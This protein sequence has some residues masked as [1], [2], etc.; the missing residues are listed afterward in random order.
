ML[1]FL[2]KAFHHGSCCTVE[3]HIALLLSSGRLRYISSTSTSNQHSFTVSYLINSCG[4]SPDA[5]LSASKY[6]HFENPHKAD[7]VISFFKHHGFSQTQISSIIRRHPTL[8]LSNPQKTL[9]P[10]LEF[11]QSKGCTSS[12]IVMILTRNPHLLKRSLKNKIIP[13]FDFFKN[14]LGTNEKT[15]I[16]VRRFSAILVNKVD[17]YAIPNVNLLRDNGVHESAICTLI[18]NWPRVITADQVRFKEIVEEVKEMG[19]SP[20]RASFVDAV[21]VIIKMN[22]STWE[23]KVNAYKRWGLYED[24]I[25]VA[26]AKNPCF[27]RASE[28]KIMRVMD[29]LVNKMGLEASLIVKR[30][31]LIS[32]SLEKRLIP[33]A[34]A[35]Q[36]LQSKGLVKKNFYLPT[37]FEYVEELF[38]QRFVLRNKEEASE[39][40]QLYKEKMDFPE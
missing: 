23:R 10:K 38:L 29:F 14:L 17:T 25:L 33:R 6:V 11:F 15:V 22:K 24:E 30:P 26:F 8:L 35:I 12:D 39:L 20:L 4:F 16:A 13:S 5:A 19:I 18:K 37:A 40:L 34:F 27:F 32:L 2:Y 9:L 7:L 28:D 1:N 36:F 31:T 21:S 3:T